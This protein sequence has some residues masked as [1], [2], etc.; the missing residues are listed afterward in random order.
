MNEIEKRLRDI[1]N[2]LIDLQS[3]EYNTFSK[4]I[5]D[6][7]AALYSDELKKVTIELKNSVDFDKFLESAEHRGS[8]VGSAR[9]VWPTERTLQLGIA[10]H[11]IDRAAEDERWLLNFGH[12]Y[13]YGGSSKFN[14]TLRQIVSNLLLPFGRDFKEFVLESYV[15]IQTSSIIPSDKS[16]VFIVHGRDEGPR[17]SVARFVQ[18][19]G[20]VPIIL[21]EQPNKGQT[22]HEKIFSNSN[23]GFAIVLL[24]PD[25]V[26]K[27]VDEIDLSPRARQ[28]VIFE[29][30]YFIGRLG[31][32][33]V[34]ALLKDNVQLPT[35]Y[36]GVAYQKYESNGRWQQDLA[37]ELQSCG[38]EID[39]NKVM[40]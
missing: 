24:T 38:F 3:A 11:I 1:N 7:R 16:R 6:L 34:C 28:N 32:E 5:N 13:Y 36:D 25:D 19:L 29:L 23:V 37:R 35:D 9:L 30:G 12:K 8:M 2:S 40:F 27:H 33:R 10:L 39:W 31:R 4:P 15:N 22:I 21:H 26:G 20:L 14:A 18:K 17:E